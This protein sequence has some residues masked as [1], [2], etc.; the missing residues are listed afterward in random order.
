MP[1]RKPRSPTG[2]W[3]TEPPDVVRYD[4][5]RLPSHGQ[6]GSIVNVSVGARLALTSAAVAVQGQE[7]RR[8]ALWNG[9]STVVGLERHVAVLGMP[10]QVAPAQRRDRVQLK[11]CGR[12]DLPVATIDPPGT[13][14]VPA[15]PTIHNRRAVKA[16]VCGLLAGMLIEVVL[17]RVVEPD[18]AIKRTKPS[19]IRSHAE[20]DRHS[21]ARRDGWSGESR[22]RFRL[23]NGV[24]LGLC[25]DQALPLPWPYRPSQLRQ[26]S[27]SVAQQL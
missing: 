9:I 2:A 15:I 7:N 1:E 26:R 8:G 22:Q 20:R 16:A 10:A 17:E 25:A 4:L 21:P 23:R 19:A 14:F 5:G 12:A 3:R 18:Y 24:I 6:G 13:G 27:V 11:L